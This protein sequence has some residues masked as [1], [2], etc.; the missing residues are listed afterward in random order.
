M[1]PFSASVQVDVSPL[2][3]NI[4]GTAERVLLEWLNR[5]YEDQRKRLFAHLPEGS[6]GVHDCSLPASS[7]CGC[8]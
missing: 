8:R 6:F 4:Y 1:P 5:L 3:S 7:M 2:R